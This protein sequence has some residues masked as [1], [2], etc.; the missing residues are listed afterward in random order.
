MYAV[1]LTALLEA[2]GYNLSY[3]I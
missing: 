2:I 1:S 3:R